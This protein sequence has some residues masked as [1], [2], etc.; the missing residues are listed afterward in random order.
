MSDI[1][2]SAPVL[3]PWIVAPALGLRY[4]LGIGEAFF[5]GLQMRRRDFMVGLGSA[6]ALPFSAWA[7]SKSAITRVAFLGVGSRSAFDPRQIEAFKQGLLENG[8]IEGRAIEIDY[9][10][11]DGDSKR[12]KELAAILGQRDLDVIITA[13]SEAALALM[14]TGTKTP[15]VFAVISDPIGTGVVNSLGRPGGNV[16]GLSMSGTDLE[17]KRVEIL[18]EAAPGTKTIMVLHDPKIGRVGVA[19]VQA[20][21]RALKL[22]PLV[23]Q[24]ADPGEFDGAFAR[25]KEQGTDALV[26]MASPFLNYHRKRL[27]ELA[28]RH[29]LP[30]IWIGAAFVREGGLLSYGPSFPDMYRRSAGYVAKIIRGEKPADIPVEQPTKFELVINLRTSKALGLEIPGVLLARADEVIE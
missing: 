18:K 6:S 15:I 14:A 22:E 3:R 23:V 8:L 11:A 27:I 29:R 21:A 7:Q 12:I 2:L 4:T 13:G 26:T 17:A 10:W 30:S 1:G 24:A 9:L 19:E 25:A 28:G 16:T 20:T 5:I